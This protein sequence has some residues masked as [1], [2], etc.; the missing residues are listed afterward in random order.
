MTYAMEYGPNEESRGLAG[1]E[2]TNA[3]QV[4]APRKYLPEFY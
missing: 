1:D 2:L 4:Q 3:N